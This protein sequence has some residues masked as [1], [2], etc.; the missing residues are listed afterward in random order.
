M[1]E[2]STIEVELAIEKLKIHK[3]PGID[4]I[5]GELITARGRT[6]RHVII[7]FIVSIWNKVELPERWKETIIVPIY[8]K[9]D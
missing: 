5:P 8:K 9:G 3:S 1:P 2:L 6:I 7:N 4:Q